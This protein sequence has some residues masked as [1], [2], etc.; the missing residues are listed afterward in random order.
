L[1]RDTAERFRKHRSRS[2][3]LALVGACVWTCAVGLWSREPLPEPTAGDLVLHFL[4]AAYAIWAIWWGFIAVW[5][6]W[7]RHVEK[8]GE[9]PTNP[10]LVA[11][12][13]A[14]A[15]IA[16][17]VYGT[18]GGGIWEFIRRRKFAGQVASKPN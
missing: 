5:D 16:G 12:L 9:G 3:I 13:F 15:L 8:A 11:A 14:L 18:L 7:M 2:L 17:I 4:C 6:P 1:R 10:R